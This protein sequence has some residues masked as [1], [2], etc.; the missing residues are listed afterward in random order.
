MKTKAAVIR[1]VGKD[2]EVT[3]LDLDRPK[4]GEVLV[5]FVAAG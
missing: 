1:D 2:W 3:E 4:E 5:R